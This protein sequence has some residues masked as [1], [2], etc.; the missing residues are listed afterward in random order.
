MQ[1]PVLRYSLHVLLC[2]NVAQ[3]LPH[4]PWFEEVLVQPWAVVA[5]EAIFEPGIEELGVECEGDGSEIG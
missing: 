2:Q 4:G 5:L 1:I 3:D